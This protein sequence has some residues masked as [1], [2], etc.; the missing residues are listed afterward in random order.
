MREIIILGSGPQWQ[1]CPFDKETWVVGKMLAMYGDKI[2]RVDMIFAMD[3]IEHILTIRRGIFTKE[4]FIEKINEREVPYYSSVRNPEIKMSRE[5]PL[6]EV[7][8]RFKVPYLANTVAYMIAYALYQGATS[9][10]LYGIAQQGAHEYASEKGSVEFWIGMA[11]GMG[12][13]VNICT[14]SLLLRNN[15]EYPYGYVRTLDELRSEGR[16]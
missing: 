8:A 5:Y 11:C 2:P 12:V 4:H 9:I 14:P 15:S 6:K 16:L 1:T 13:E 10:S 3:D 7:M